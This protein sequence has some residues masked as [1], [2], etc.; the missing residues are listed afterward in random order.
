MFVWR[1]LTRMAVTRACIPS[2][3]IG[4]CDLR[5]G[6]GRVHDEGGVD[7]HDACVVEEH[8]AIRPA[9]D[10]DAADIGA[11]AP[12]VARHVLAD[13]RQGFGEVGDE[14]R[15]VDV[16]ALVEK[17]DRDAIDDVLV[18]AGRIVPVAQGWWQEVAEHG[19]KDGAGYL[20]DQPVSRM[21]FQ[22]P[23]G[24]LRQRVR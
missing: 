19:G 6:E 18:R 16:V 20:S 8:A 13:Q 21:I 15:I 11:Q 9:L 4:R 24:C 3:R 10:P 23:S 22:R 17:P 12:E 7:H 14:L 2:C 5:A 1:R